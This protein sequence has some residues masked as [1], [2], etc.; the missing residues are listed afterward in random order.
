[1]RADALR[2][3]ARV[4]EVAQ[5]VFAAEGMGVPIAEIAKRAGVGIGTVY[6]QFPTKEALFAAIVQDKIDRLADEAASLAGEARPGVAF[7]ALLDRMIAGSAQKRDLVDSLAGAGVDVKSVA[8][9]SS[10]RLR[11]ALGK[12]L[13]RAQAA[14][15]VRGD[16]DVAELLALMAATLEAARRSGT[17]STRLFA[18]MRDGLQKKQS[19][20]SAAKSKGGFHGRRNGT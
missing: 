10:G 18:V 4:L 9:A 14:G 1:V 8:A 7:F 15:A 6:R 19:L 17:S 3:R 20:A 11:V 13:R 12:L 5:R 16:V 2:N